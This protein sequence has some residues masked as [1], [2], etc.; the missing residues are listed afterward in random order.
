MLKFSP[1]ITSSSSSSQ[2]SACFTSDIF[3]LL[4]R[5]RIFFNSLGTSGMNHAVIILSSPMARMKEMNAIIL[6]SKGYADMVSVVNAK[7]AALVTTAVYIVIMIKYCH[8]PIS[9][10]PWGIG[11]WHISVNL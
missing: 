4:C 8:V 9:C 3:R 5:W 7:R 6:I 1:L 10:A 2:S 11:C